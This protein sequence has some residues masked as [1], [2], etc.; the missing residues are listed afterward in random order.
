MAEVLA[1]G[2]GERCKWNII[3]SHFSSFRCTTFILYIL[4]VWLFLCFMTRDV[5]LVSML[6]SSQTWWKLLFTLSFNKK[7]IF[8]FLSSRNIKIENSEWRCY[9]R[10][11]SDW[12]WHL[13]LVSRINKISLWKLEDLKRRFYF[14]PLLIY[15]FASQTFHQLFYPNHVK[16]V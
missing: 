12:K 13:F 9:L 16:T 3:I 14:I 15:W 6:F 7:S 4:C 1:V 11:E 8:I 5:R 10:L 2:G